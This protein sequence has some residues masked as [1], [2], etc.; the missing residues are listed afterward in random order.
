LHPDYVQ[1]N[2]YAAPGVEGAVQFFGGFVRAFPDL[3]VKAEDVLQAGDR[4]AGRFTYEGT[5]RGEFMGAPPTERQICM[6]SIDIWRTKDGLLAEHCDEINTLEFLQQLRL[7]SGNY[8]PGSAK[9][10]PPDVSNIRNDKGGE[11]L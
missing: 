8:A 11:G 5:H 10:N 6:T 2:R 7:I 4:L 9:E 1:H 3:V